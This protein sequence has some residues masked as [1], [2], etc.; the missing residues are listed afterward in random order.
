MEIARDR[1][2][3]LEE[4]RK[5]EARG[6]KGR[7]MQKAEREIGRRG[8]VQGKKRTKNEVMMSVERD[9]NHQKNFIKNINH[10]NFDIIF[11]QVLDFTVKLRKFAE[12]SFQHYADINQ[13]MREYRDVRKKIQANHRDC[14]CHGSYSR[15]DIMKAYESLGLPKFYQRSP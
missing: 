7:M 8:I 5:E 6:K 11:Q 15:E 1:N 13:Y 14:A 2:E 9:F 3:A 12:S 4:E 10:H